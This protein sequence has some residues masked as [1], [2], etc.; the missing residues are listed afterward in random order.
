MCGAYDDPMRLLSR[1]GLGLFGWLLPACVAAAAACG[2]DTDDGSVAGSGG[3]GAGTTSESS[4]T[5]AGTGTGGASS[6]AGLSCTLGQICVNPCCGGEEPPCY[7][8]PEDG[9]ACPTG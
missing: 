2:S 5:G 3:S 4:A 1:H 7:P 9:G 6:C 8:A